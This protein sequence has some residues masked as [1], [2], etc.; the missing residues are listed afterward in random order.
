MG[1]LERDR[2]SSARS[3]N[4]WNTGDGAGW[5]LRWVR[6]PRSQPGF[7]PAATATDT[8]G[9]IRQPAPLRASPASKPTYGRVALHGMIAFASEPRPGRPDHDQRRGRRLLLGGTIAASTRATHQRRYAGAGLCRD[10]R[11]RL[12][13]RAHRAGEEFFDKRAS[14]RSAGARIRRGARGLLSRREAGGGFCPNLPLSVPTY[15]VV[16]PAECSVEPRAL[17]RR[18]RHGHRREN[19]KNLIDLYRRRSRGEGFG[20]EVK[21]R[22]MRPGTHVLRRYHDAYL[23]QGAAR[24]LIGAADFARAFGRVRRAGRPDLADAGVP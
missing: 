9:S 2:S 23:P 3:G 22:I 10:P 16:A 5:L 14:M 13:G 24:Q 12:A 7:A 19:P 8:G 18:A 11:R 4:P 17:R 15:Y 20:A 6:P 21:R 1:S